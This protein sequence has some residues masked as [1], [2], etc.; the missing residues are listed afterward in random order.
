MLD[1]YTMVFHTP[2]CELTPLMY[3]SMWGPIVLLVIIGAMAAIK[4]L[5]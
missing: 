2:S 3:L 1:W 5:R 4:V